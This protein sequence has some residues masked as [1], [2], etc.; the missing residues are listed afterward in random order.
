MSAINITALFTLKAIWDDFLN[1][2]TFYRNIFIVWFIV[3][4]QDGPIFRPT[5]QGVFHS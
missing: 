1:D 5:F 3:A 4:C 2:I